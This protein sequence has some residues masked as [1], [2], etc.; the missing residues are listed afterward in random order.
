[1]YGCRLIGMIPCSDQFGVD[2]SVDNYADIIEKAQLSEIDD[3]ESS[4]SPRKIYREISANQQD[5]TSINDDY[6]KPDDHSDSDFS[7]GR[8]S[9][10]LRGKDKRENKIRDK[11]N[12]LNERE[13]KIL[14]KEIEIK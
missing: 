2:I 7:L 5:L 10:P 12:E 9:L 8:M 4:P 1:M 6:H 11:E 3:A 14:A 13:Q